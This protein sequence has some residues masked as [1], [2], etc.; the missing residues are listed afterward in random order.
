MSDADEVVDA[1]KALHAEQPVHAVMGYDDEVMP[2]VSRIA[3]TL[4]L[5]G[6]PLET[7][8]AT[9]DKVLMKERLRAG[10]VPIAPF[11]VARDEDDAVAWAERTGYPVVVKPVRGAGSQG[12]I[13][14]DSE[15]DLRGAYRWLCRIVQEHGLDTGARSDTEQLV[16]TYLDGSEFTVELLAR[17]GDLHVLCEFEKPFPLDGPYF[18]ESIYVTPA[19][20]TSEQ[21]KE[22]QA[23]AKQAARALGIRNGPVHCELRL[24]SEGL[25]VIEI[26]S[27]LIGGACS[28][29]FPYVFGENM[30]EC[31]LNIALGNQLPLP[32]QQPAAA[33]A[34]MLPVPRKG[35]LVSVNGVEAARQ[36]PGIHDVIVTVNSGDIICTYPEQGCYVG[37]LTASASTRESVIDAL[38][39]ACGL[40]DLEISPLAAATPKPAGCT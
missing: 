28:R 17:D 11:T 19:S 13:R 5:V 18:E 40:I 33:G 37:L 20:L 24:S 26:A 32:R 23:L 4:G 31:I 22:M 3:T 35:R 8:I 2:L 34:M 9:R 25:F 36:V 16:E 15:M 29:V 6:N 1:A 38:T 39:K 27:R 12:V 14:A 21:R 7:A 30:H 10:G